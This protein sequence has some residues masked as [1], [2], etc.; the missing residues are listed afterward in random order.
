MADGSNK[1]MW[2]MTRADFKGNGT[3]TEEKSVN[4]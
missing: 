2:M 4:A 3:L 1:R